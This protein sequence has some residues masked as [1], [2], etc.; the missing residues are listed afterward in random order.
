MIDQLEALET[1]IEGYEKIISMK[2]EERLFGE[3]HGFKDPRYWRNWQSA[4]AQPAQTG[5]IALPADEVQLVKDL[6]RKLAREFHP[7]LAEDDDDVRY[8]ER[9][10]AELN[11]AYAVKNLAILKMLAI[12]AKIPPT[13]TRQ[14]TPKPKTELGRLKLEIARVQRRLNEIHGE[15][16]DLHNHPSVQLSLDVKLARREGRDLLR[17]M[18]G[19]YKKKIQRK[20]AERDYLKAQ[21]D[22]SGLSPE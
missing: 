4:E 22:Q 11:D 2:R 19:D 3:D 20:T 21:L 12:E 13:P 10:M 16:G 8:L 17:E 9:K 15:L 18:A 6:Y 7:D 5:P 1:E 14:L